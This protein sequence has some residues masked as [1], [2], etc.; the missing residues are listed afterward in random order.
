M[1]KP[2]CFV[3]SARES[4]EYVNAI[5]SQLRFDAEVTPWHAGVFQVN[6]YPMESLERVLGA[7]DFAVFVF[8]PDDVVQMRGSVYVA[9]RD[10]SLFEMGLFWGRLRRDRVFFLIPSAVPEE[11]S[12]MRVEGFHLASDLQGMNVL[13]YDVRSDGNV[14][15]AV[16]VPCAQIIERIRRLGSY[17]DPHK[18]LAEA[19]AELRCKQNLLHFF[20][21]FNKRLLAGEADDA[22]LYEA[23]RNAFDPAVQGFRVTGVAIWKAEATGIRQM[24]GNVGRDRFYSYEANR[25]GADEAPILVLEAYQH[26]EVRVC[27]YNRHIAKVYLICYPVGKEYVIT[28]HLSGPVELSERQLLQIDSDNRELMNTI[29]YLLGGD[30]S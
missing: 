17:A 13:H 21:E 29:H 18:G 9:P 19:R 27:L 28:T 8:S 26:R 25:E 14:A 1:D 15:A 30:A 3:G 6:D 7:S 5:H 20:L 23:V 4:I 16:N 11:Q 10:N 2:A 24:A 22:S 12:G